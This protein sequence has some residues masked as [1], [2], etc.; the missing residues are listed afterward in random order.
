MN[1]CKYR[2][3][4]GWCDKRNVKCEEQANPSNDTDINVK[5]CDSSCIYTDGGVFTSLPPKVKCKVTGEYRTI[6]SMCNAFVT[7]TTV[8]CTAD[9]TKVSNTNCQT[10]VEG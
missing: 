5:L 9:N 3:P 1:N 10:E 4:C 8:S 6:G 2:L 7:G